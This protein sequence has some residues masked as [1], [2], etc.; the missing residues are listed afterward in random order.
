MDKNNCANLV[1]FAQIR[2]RLG[3]G[4]LQYPISKAMTLFELKKELQGI[5]PVWE[6]VFSSEVLCAVNQEISSWDRVIKSNDEIAFFPP[7]TGG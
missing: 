5:D 1:F 2:E 6:D 7:V 3:K 4:T